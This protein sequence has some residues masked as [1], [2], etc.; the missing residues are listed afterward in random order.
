MKHTFLI[1]IMKIGIK[2]K[3]NKIMKQKL[4][5]EAFINLWRWVWIS[6]RLNLIDG[7]SVALFFIGSAWLSSFVLAIQS[8]FGKEILYQSSRAWLRAMYILNE[9]SVSTTGKRFRNVLDWYFEDLNLTDAKKV[10][11]NNSNQQAVSFIKQLF[12][13]LILK[14]VICSNR[15]Q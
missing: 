9:E 15:A 11:R 4:F 14:F 6:V 12:F 10:D 3:N 8:N 5:I 1:L 7:S 2:R 13:I